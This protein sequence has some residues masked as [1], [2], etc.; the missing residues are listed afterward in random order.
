[1]EKAFK[2]NLAID[3]GCD[4]L[5][6]SCYAHVSASLGYSFAMNNRA[7]SS[8]TMLSNFLGGYRYEQQKIKK[9]NFQGL[10]EREYKR[11]HT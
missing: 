4:L 10:Y 8:L 3:F 7:I 2:M 1:M 6:G 11:N 5:D 9:E